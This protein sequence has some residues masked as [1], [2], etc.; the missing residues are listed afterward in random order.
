MKFK[1]SIPAII[2]LLLISVLFFPMDNINLIG[3][4]IA[5]ALILGLV[6]W[7]MNK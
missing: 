7:R 2:L 5:L 1:E 3:I 6:Y 4:P